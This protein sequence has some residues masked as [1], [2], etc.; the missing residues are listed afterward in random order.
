MNDYPSV[1]YIIRGDSSRNGN[2]RV[3]CSA[4]GGNPL[5]PVMDPRL[6]LGKGGDLNSEH[7]FDSRGSLY[8][9]D[10]IIR[11]GSQ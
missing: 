6:G 7:S 9:I 4:S 5:K 1:L 11:V 2:N 10:P 3:L 8:Q